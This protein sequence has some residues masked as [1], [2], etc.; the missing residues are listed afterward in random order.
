M[1]N[2]TIAALVYPLTSDSAK[3]TNALS[4]CK[5]LSELLEHIP[6]TVRVQMEVVLKDLHSVALKV[7]NAEAALLGFEKA[8]VAHKWPAPLQGLKEPVVMLTK[9]Y[10]TS[11]A[12]A[13]ADSAK[14]KMHQLFVEYRDAQLDAMIALKR[15]EVQWLKT[16]RLRADAWLPKLSKI[17]EGAYNKVKENSQWLE[18]ETNKA[19]SPPWIEQERKAYIEDLRYYGTRVIEMA[20]AKSQ[21]EL[22]QRF[23]KI[24]L[25]E[26]VDIEMT[27]AQESSI[28]DI[29]D[30][31]FNELLKKNEHQQVCIPADPKE[32]LF[33]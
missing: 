5:T 17:V 11:T 30:K 6:V 33:F 13:S 23:A 22:E 29:I 19:S 26:K 8:K 15:E 14:S 2:S 21:A 20:R 18:P 12:V 16:E 7:C 10:S 27:D 9:E 4:L 28:S 31:K 32:Q 24:Q 25:K 1:V 3:R